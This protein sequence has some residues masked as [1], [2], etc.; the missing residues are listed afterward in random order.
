MKKI[1]KIFFSFF[2]I[3]IVI[4]QLNNSVYAYTIDQVKDLIDY[5]EV[6]EDGEPTECDILLK[7][8]DME[9]SIEFPLIQTTLEMIVYGKQAIKEKT[10]VLANIIDKIDLLEINFFD[11][12]PNNGSGLWNKIRNIV[13]TG[14]RVTLYIS[15]GLMLTLL[16]YIGFVIV[17]RTISNEHVKLPLSNTFYSSAY[18]NKKKLT[19]KELED[20][21][22]RIEKSFIEQWILS[23][24]LLLLTI[25][26]MTS[27]INF[28]YLIESLY[29]DKMT[30]T[31]SL[32]VYVMDDTMH[33]YGYYFKTNVQGAYLFQ[34]QRSWAKFGM[35]N[36][37]LLICSTILIIYKAG[38]YG[39]Y[40]CRMILLAFL[41]MVFPIIILINAF[42]RV[43]YGD[44]YLS[45]KLR[46]KSTVAD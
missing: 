11:E 9:T 16:I 13:R 2:I 33:D 14:T 25:F 28:S 12:N 40:I 39:I 26:I 15:F 31:R 23:F 7:L 43:M 30:P 1:L 20:N 27:I 44:K 37:L 24:I 21:F 42:T 38:L 45:G 8:S 22:K 3:Y 34:S 4:C 5:H 41:S 6:A 17:K 19:R 10:D 32:Q 29:A 35:H 46:K 18:S 36:F